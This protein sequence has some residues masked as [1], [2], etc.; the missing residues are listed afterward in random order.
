M[1]LEDKNSTVVKVGLNGRITIPQ[2]MR[3]K[4]DITSGTKYRDGDL[5]EIGF[6]DL[7]SSE[8]AT[9]FLE[10]GSNGRITIPEGIRE[11]LDLEK[12]DLVKISVKH[13]EKGSET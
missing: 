10:V 6:E 11:Y 13:A 9:S 7:D 4:L 12:D 8:K 1:S 2:G 5:L 3:K